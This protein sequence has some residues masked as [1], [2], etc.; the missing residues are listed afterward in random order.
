MSNSRGVFSDKRAAIHNKTGRAGVLIINQPLMRKIF[1]AALIATLAMPSQAQ[2]NTIY[3]PDV[4][5]LQVVANQNW[6]SPP[7][8]E[9]HSGDV[10]NV[11]FDELSHNYRRFTYHIDHCEA[12]WSVS[13]ELFDSDFIAGFNDNPI[14]DYENSLN[15]TVMYTHYKL[16]IPNDRCRLRMSGNYRLTIL[17]EDGGKVAEAEFMVVEPI[18]AIGME[19]SGNTDIDINKRHQQVTLSLNYGNMTITNPEE[20]LHIVVTQNGGRGDRRERMKPD[21][22]NSKGLQWRHCRELIFEGGNE[23]HKYEILDVS[24]PTMG[25]AGIVWD[26]HNYHAAPYPSVPRDVNYLYDEDADGAFYIRNSD[27]TENDY[28]CDYVFV[29]YKLQTDEVEGGRMA[30]DGQW[31][32]DS[33]QDNY[34]MDYDPTDNSYNAVIMQK[35]GYYSYRYVLLADDGTRA[36]AP[37]EGSYWRTENR[38]QAYAYYRGNGD[39]TWRLVGYRNAEYKP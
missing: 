7:V 30:I 1:T 36:T 11:S 20:Q 18:M 4:R 35:Q 25:I 26:G 13:G 9:L 21:F 23:Y 39:R 37:T 31:T 8:M 33:R 32:T 6:L 29:H 27:N 22:V 10:L 38:Y 14:E 16:Q 28:T 17:D 5:T 2:R 24:H 3:S 34:V 12:D 19:V 15:T